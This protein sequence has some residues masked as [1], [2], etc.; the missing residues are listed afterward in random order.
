MEMHFEL[1]LLILWIGG[2]GLLS[3]QMKGLRGSDQDR[4]PDTPGGLCL[5]LSVPCEKEGCARMIRGPI[6]VSPP[7]VAW[8]ENS[9]RLF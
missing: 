9:F 2:G 5:Q 8:V 6:L 1:G 4:V 3:M 7:A